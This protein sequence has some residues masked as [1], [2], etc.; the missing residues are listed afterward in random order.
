MRNDEEYLERLAKRMQ[1]QMSHTAREPVT[2]VL[3][4]NAFFA[5]GSELATLRLYRHYMSTLGLHCFTGWSPNLETYY[6]KI[7]RTH[8]TE[9]V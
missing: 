6:F 4:D 7:E 9:K 1:Q 2:V 5:Y 8:V 3:I